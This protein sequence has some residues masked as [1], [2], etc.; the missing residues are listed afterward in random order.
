[1]K[2]KIYLQVP[3]YT[4]QSHVIEIIGMPATT[5]TLTKLYSDISLLELHN[6]L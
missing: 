1:M 3:F 6:H 2:V 4:S 5:M